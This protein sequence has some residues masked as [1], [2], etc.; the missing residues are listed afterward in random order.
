MPR[1][2]RK[3][4]RGG[5]A[6]RNPN[7]LANLRRGPGPGPPL[8][9]PPKGN[10]RS[11]RHGGRA[12]VTIPGLD[13]ARRDI[14]DRLAASAPVRGP[15]GE[16][17]AADEATVA[18]AAR[19]LAR[20]RSVDNWLAA[21]GVLDEKTGEPK[22]AVYYAESSARTA[23]GLLAKLGMNPKDRAALGLDI[24]RTSHFDL[25]RHWAE[26]ESIDAEAE[27]EIEE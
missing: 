7:S 23:D 8:P 1:G 4:K 16:L 13:A 18:L 26:E 21:H 15:E 9:P 10:T 5:G 20:H 17:P 6:A 12:E 19:A 14:Y 11:L 27:E 24:A 2:R 3:K 22:K 25:A